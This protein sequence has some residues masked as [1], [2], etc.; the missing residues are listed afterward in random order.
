MGADFMP[1]QAILDAPGTLHNVIFRKIEKEDK[2]SKKEG[3]L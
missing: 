1:R 3:A 2:G